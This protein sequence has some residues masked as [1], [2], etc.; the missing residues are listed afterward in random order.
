MENSYPILEFD[1]APNAIINP[2]SYSLSVPCPQ[3]GLV[4]FFQEVIHEL[5][6]SGQAYPIGNLISEIG[7]NPLYELTWEGERFLLFHPGVGAP[8]AAGFLDEVIAL[9]VNKFIACGGCGVLDKQIITGHPVILTSAVRDEGTSYHYLAPS[10]EVSAHPA[11]IQ[12][13]E[14]TFKRH[15]I[16]YRL[17][18]SWTT[19]AFYRETNQ[20]RALR[21]AEGCEVVEME[22]SAFFAVAQ[23]R[24]VEFGQAVYG[25]DLLLPD[26]YDDRDWHNRIDDRRL[27]FWLAVEACS[28][29]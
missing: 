10:R 3:K 13:L 7:N 8:L 23:F 26:T 28:L 17:G 21:M 22:A 15:A 20:R 2:Y 5:V 9:G 1:P 19:D 29:L 11:A 16:D 18:K 14:N 12:A 25:G 27:I 24:G 6:D 4:C